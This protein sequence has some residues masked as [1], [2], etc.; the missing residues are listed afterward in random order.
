MIWMLPLFSKSNFINDTVV[1]PEAYCQVVTQFK[2][3]PI[4]PI[5]EESM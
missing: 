5:Q 3:S 4:H 1:I 2:E